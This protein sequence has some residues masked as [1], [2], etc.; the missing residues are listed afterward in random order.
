VFTVV[1]PIIDS[2]NWYDYG[3]RMYGSID[4]RFVSMDPMAEKFPW[5]SSYAY[6]ANDPIKFIN[7]NGENPAI[8]IAVGVAAVDAF[9][10][11]TGI[12]ATGIILHKAADG[13]LAINSN[14]TDFFYKDNP[15]YRE[16]QKREG[17]SQRET[18]QIKQ[19]HDKSVDNNVGKPSPDGGGTPKGGGSTVGKV[20]V[21]VGLA[22]EFTKGI[23]E[24]TSTSNQNSSEK[25]SNG[26]TETTI[27]QGPTTSKS[28]SSTATNSVFE[29]PF[30]TIPGDNKRVVTPKVSLEID[31]N[32]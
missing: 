14:I 27:S 26:N 22:A 24:S 25:Q 30:Y 17:A 21:G 16:Q 8:P 23:L 4:S 28:A 9:L 20:A 19:N 12:V 10:I 18:S 3:A 11:A 5:Q 31:E 29:T 32:N 2:L 15:G 1:K 7:K 6:A 13:S